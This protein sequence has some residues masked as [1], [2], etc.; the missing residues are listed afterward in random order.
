[1]R[2][3]ILIFL[4]AAAV[5]QTPRVDNARLETRAL[6]ESLGKAMARI[7]GTAWAGYEMPAHGRSHYGC[8][9]WNSTTAH[10]EGDKTVYVLY[11]LENGS[12]TKLQITSSSCVLDTAGLPLLWFTGVKPEETAGYLTSLANPKGQA[13]SQLRRNALFLMSQLAGE[14]MAAQI[15]DSAENDPDTAVKKHAV[16]ALPQLPKDQ[17]IPLLIDLAKS[18]RNAEVRRQ[19]V[20]WLGQSG[21]ARAFAF[22]ASVLT[23]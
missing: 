9:D 10:L 11:K 22:I 16:F 17:G 21:D 18:N 23:K 19:A 12:P 2:P 7:P 4:A 13:S 8:N 20:F 14:K 6:S 1:M 15:R 3:Y 5:A